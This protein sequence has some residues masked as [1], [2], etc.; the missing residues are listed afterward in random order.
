MSGSFTSPGS[1]V[2]ARVTFNSGTIDF[3]SNR[4]VDVD[5]I[6]IDPNWTSVPMY[7]LNSIKMAALSRSSFVVTITA[8]IMSWSPEIDGLLYGS[9]VAG[10]PAEITSL[11]GQPTLQN[12]VITCFDSNGKEFQYQVINAIFTADSITLT[13]EQYVK[14]SISITAI[15]INIVYTA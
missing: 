4:L 10:T 6:K 5:N 13:Q 15:D 12:P 2:P 7:V 9:S 8:D 1:N 3:G 11:D 14:W